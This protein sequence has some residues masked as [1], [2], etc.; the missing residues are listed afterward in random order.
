MSEYRIECKICDGQ[1][2]DEI[3]NPCLHCSG[4]G[5]ETV[6]E[7]EFYGEDK[8]YNDDM[9]DAGRER[10]IRHNE[11]WYNYRVIPYKREEN[12]V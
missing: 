5:F 4:K 9:A 3:G 10:H 8:D 11:A 2:H 12:N 6:S 1:G 7:D